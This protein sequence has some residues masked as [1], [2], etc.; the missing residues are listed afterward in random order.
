MVLEMCQ[1]LWGVMVLSLYR[2][3]MHNLF[4]SV[5]ASPSVPRQNFSSVAQYFYELAD[6]NYIKME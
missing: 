4:I 5:G 6:K 1:V 3:G 2:F